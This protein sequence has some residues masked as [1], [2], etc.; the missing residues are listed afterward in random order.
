M[1]VILTVLGLLMLLVLLRDLVR[2]VS[3]DG[4]GTGRPPRSH[5]E[6]LGGHAEQELRR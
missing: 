6:E 2:L 3:G 4:R 1:N 5:R